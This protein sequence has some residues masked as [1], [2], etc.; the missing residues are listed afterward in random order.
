MQFISKYGELSLTMKSD[1]TYIERGRTVIKPGRHIH[2]HD[3]QFAT[4]D[5][6]EIAFL[7]NHSNFGIDFFS[8]KADP[9]DKLAV[10]RKQL[11]SDDQDL[12]KKVE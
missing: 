1:E 3:N 10:T 7:R 2:F 5:Q 6:K 12:N 11:S 8:V 9:V 4:T